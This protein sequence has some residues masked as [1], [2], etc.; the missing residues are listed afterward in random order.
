MESQE[1][2][3]KSDQFMVTAYSKN[4]ESGHQQESA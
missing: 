2:D 1:I 3:N 4:W